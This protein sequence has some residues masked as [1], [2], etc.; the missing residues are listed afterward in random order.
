MVFLCMVSR[1]DI[2][3]ALSPLA[4]QADLHDLA[5]DQGRVTLLLGVDP[6]QGTD[7]ET[8]RQQAE[9]R[10]RGVKGVTEVMAILTSEKKPAVKSAPDPHGMHKN[11]PLTLPVRHIIAVGSGKGGVGKS[12]LAFHLA[13][14]LARTG[15]KV[16]LLDADIYGPSVPRLAGLEGMKPEQIDGQIQPFERY[17]IK[18]MSIGFMVSTDQALIWRGPMAQSAFYQLLRDVAWG[19]PDDLLDILIIDL[20]PGTGDIQLTLAQKV[21]MTGAIIVSTPQDLALIDAR[22]AVAMFQKVN[23]PIL[24]LIENMSVYCCPK[25]GYEDHIFGKGGA[26]HEAQ[27]LGVPLLGEIPLNIKIREACDAGQPAP[28]DIFDRVA[29]Q[30]LGRLESV[31]KE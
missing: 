21:P 27:V 16:G 14:A 18:L 13:T 12:T 7:I 3:S 11:P 17:G 30:V 25:C 1:D 9:S 20:P 22:K 31:T 24:G 15:K 6:A 10:V 2:L 26:V 19:T 23:V 8:L 5:I 4:G 29:A 28:P